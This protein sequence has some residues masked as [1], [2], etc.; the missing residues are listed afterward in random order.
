[1]SEAHTP[2]YVGMSSNDMVGILRDDGQKW[3]A[4]FC[5]TAKKLGYGELEE[6]WVFG[7]FANAIECS[8]D[9]RATSLRTKL[10]KAERALEA[11]GFGGVDGRAGEKI[12]WCGTF[13]APSTHEHF[14]CEFCKVEYLDVRDDAHKEDCPVVFCRAAISSIRGEKEPANV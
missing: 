13:P 9:L 12:G 3:A 8:H 2:N 1:M 7:W 14:R 5:Q 6:D 4:A 11:L 10:A